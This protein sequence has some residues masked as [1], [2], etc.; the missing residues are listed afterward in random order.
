MRASGQG[1]PSAPP[2]GEPG[3]LRAWAPALLWSAIIF[4]LSSIPGNRLPPLPGWWNADK[5]VH[6]A[7]YA[8]LGM[9]C[10]RGLRATW[11]RGYGNGMQIGAA[12]ALTAL[13][14]ITDE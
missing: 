10:W 12:V 7:V 2:T 8:V 13:Y 9:L 14:G 5:F 11:A 3:W 4:A 1:D 6:G